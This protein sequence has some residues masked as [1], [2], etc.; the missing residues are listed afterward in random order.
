MKGRLPSKFLIS[1]S[2]GS[3]FILEN[4]G[5]MCACFTPARFCFF[6]PPYKN[7]HNF[8]DHGGF[9]CF[10]NSTSS[11]TKLVFLWILSMSAPSSTRLIMIESALLFTICKFI[12]SCLNSSDKWVKL[13]TNG[14]SKTCARQSLKNLKWYGLL[15]QTVSLQI[16]ERLSSTNFTWSILEYLDPNSKLRCFKTYK[17]EYTNYKCLDI[18]IENN[19]TDFN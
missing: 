11:G 1:R 3:I 16:F 10:K 13:F 9:W 15:R 8:F 17:I 12:K 2:F 18:K 6:R 19:N 5:Y 7:Q 14:S 4:C